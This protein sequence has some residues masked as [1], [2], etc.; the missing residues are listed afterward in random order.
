MCFGGKTPAVTAPPPPPSQR[1]ANLEGVDAR[2]RAAAAAKTS[3]LESTIATSATGV[4]GAAPTL[5]P[6]LGG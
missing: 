3:G 2:R 6:T 1:D 4:A 5:K